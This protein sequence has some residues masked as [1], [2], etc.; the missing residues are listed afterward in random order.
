M[1]RYVLAVLLAVLVVA[2]AAADPPATGEKTDSCLALNNRILGPRA[3]E[4]PLPLL[5]GDPISGFHAACTVPW[6]KLSPGNQPLAVTD[7][8]RGSLLQVANTAA[9][10]RPTGPLW[11]NSRWVVTSA[12]LADTHSH[13]AFCQQLE[14]GA[15]AGTRDLKIDCIPQKKEL[16]MDLVPAPKASARSADS[17]ASAAPPAASSASQPPAAPATAP[18]HLNP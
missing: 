16:S 11:I 9:C 1:T 6:S 13:A 5:S 7:C 2:L 14:T 15:W 10:G 17:P 8:Y 12:E 4:R 3:A 18:P